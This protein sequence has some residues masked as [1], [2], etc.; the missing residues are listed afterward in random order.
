MKSKYTI[1]F[2]PKIAEKLEKLSEEEQITKAE[3]LK[4][5]II[6]YDVFLEELEKGNK[7]A[8]LDQDNKLIKEI[9]LT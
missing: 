6:V 3:I 2:P 8:I 7:I 5:S 4:K 1:G 9:L